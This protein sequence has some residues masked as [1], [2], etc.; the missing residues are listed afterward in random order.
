MILK[1]NKTKPTAGRR[2]MSCMDNVVAP[3]PTAASRRSLTRRHGVGR[4]WATP[5]AILARWPCL[6]IPRVAVYADD[7]DHWP[8]AYNFAVSAWRRCVV[9]AMDRCDSIPQ[10][11]HERKKYKKKRILICHARR[12]GWMEPRFFCFSWTRT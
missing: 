7:P 6:V 10:Y 11:A 2:V 5:T 8:S 9:L 4:H 1:I 12:V 3:W